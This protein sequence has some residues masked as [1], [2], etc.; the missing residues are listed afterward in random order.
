VSATIS[1][2]APKEAGL[3]YAALIA[4]GTDLLQKLSGAIWTDYNYSDPG[5][6]LLEQLCYAL[7]ELSY[8]AAFPVEDILG[9][10]VTGHIALQRQG[11]YPA[12]SIMPVNPVTQNDLRRLIIDS[13]PAVRNAWCIPLTTNDTNGISGLYRIVVIAARDEAEPLAVDYAYVDTSRT[14]FASRRQETIERVLDCYGAHRALCEDVHTC[15]VVTGIPT[16]ISANVQLEDGCDPDSVMAQLLFAVGLAFMPEPKRTSLN[17]QLASGATTSAIFNGPLM[18]RGF[19]PDDQL[20][21]LP[22]EVVV[23]DLL[24]VMVTVDGVLS[25]DGLT[26]QVG[27]NPYEYSVTE[28]IPLPD[29]HLLQ[30]DNDGPTGL[31]GVRLLYEGAL[32]TPHPLRVRRLLDRAWA[33]QRR[34]YPLWSDYKAAYKSPT[35]RGQALKAYS[36]IQNQFPATYGVGAYGL[37]GNADAA[38]R[39][40]A[41]QLKGYLMPFD[42]LMANY[43]AQLAFVPTLFSIRAGGEQTYAVQSL[44]GIVP[45]VEPLLF[46]GYREALETLAAQRDPLAERQSAVLDFLL[47]LYAQKLVAPPPSMGDSTYREAQNAG[48]IAAKQKLLLQMV[49]A[50]R[51]RGRAMDYRHGSYRRDVAGLEIRCRIELGLLNVDR[52]QDVDDDDDDP[53]DDTAAFANNGEIAH[54]RDGH[55]HGRHGRSKQHRRH[56]HHAHDEI[57]DLYLVEWLLLRH[58]LIAWRQDDA[59]GTP[60]LSFRIGAVMPDYAM[61]HATDAPLRTQMH[62]ADRAERRPDKETTATGWRQQAHAIVRQN[63]PAHILVDVLFLPPRAMRHFVH[64]YHAW[65]RALRHGPAWRNASTSRRLARF[66]HA[67]RHAEVG[68]RPHRISDRMREAAIEIDIVLVDVSPAEDDTNPIA[69]DGK[70]G[71]D[72]SPLLSGN[73]PTSEPA[74]PEYAASASSAA[75]T[76][77]PMVTTA[78]PT[79]APPVQAQTDSATAAIPAEDASPPAAAVP[80]MPPRKRQWWQFWQRHATTAPVPVTATPAVT[81]SE[82]STSTS[83]S[84]S[85]FTSAL[86]IP[87]TAS[88]PAAIAP[89]NQPGAAQIAPVSAVPPTVS[90][91]P[92][93]DVITPAPVANTTLPGTVVAAWAGA[94]GFDTD[95]PLTASTAQAFADAAFVFVLRYISRGSTESKS[96]LSTAEAQAI[97]QAGLALMP[98]QHV[99][100][101]GWTPSAAL[102][103]EYGNNAATHARQ[104]GFPDGVNVWLDLEGIAANTPATAVV[105]YCNAWYRAVAQANYLP[106]L[107]VGANAILDGAELY[108]QL[109]FQRYWQS[110]SHVPEVATRGYCMAQTI[111]SSDV[112]AGVTYDLDVTQDDNLGDTPCWLQAAA[113]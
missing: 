75:T 102:G 93:N 97:L 96:D 92:A 30:L 40:Q 26:V 101:A 98:V 48:H 74:S 63:I 71:T 4:E 78:A 100:A 1:R 21:A 24:A 12:R 62:D 44:L 27:D 36:S 83:T 65:T 99:A 68:I 58:G 72:D 80:S 104:V 53:R 28:V 77:L 49:P 95:T 87:Q 35:G 47:S 56:R 105:D 103:T 33:E 25:I 52:Q 86:A 7:T 91:P 90:A 9:A 34:T 112:L 3:N 111:S 10:P 67:Y 16:R 66:L 6:T 85:T 5:V 45:N 14:A 82:A 110:G 20:H 57:R 39:A 51:D 84:P 13:V 59:K 22:R 31:A 54:H 42:Q 79:A 50:T 38:R 15:C 108:S 11:M 18:L 17:R 69:A 70:D 37:P 60:E 61:R 29:D 32:C 109:S 88:T 2:T 64:L 55:R 81:P 73:A 106:G 113:S 23:A 41:K 43:F 76:P 8:R 107:Y 46:P 89:T 94:K 19:I